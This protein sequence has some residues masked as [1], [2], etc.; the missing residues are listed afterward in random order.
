MEKI[1]VVHDTVGQTL[2]VWF[3]DPETES[4][5]EETADEVVLMKNANGRMI[6][7]ELLHYSPTD[8]DGL[9]VETV[10]RSAP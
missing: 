5:C 8:V 7:F 9:V 1:K 2:T 3:D 4:P 10:L 6:G